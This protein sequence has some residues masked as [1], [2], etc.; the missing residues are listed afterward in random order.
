MIDEIVAAGY[1]KILIINDGST[2]HTAQIIKQ[3][4]QEHTDV[5][6]LTANHIINRGGGCA[7]RT[8]FAF[9]SAY[10]EEL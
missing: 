6:L 3:K 8:G 10:G 5:L 7:N 2:D 1:H 9:L 4:Q